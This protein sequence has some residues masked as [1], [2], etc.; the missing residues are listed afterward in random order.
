MYDWNAAARFLQ[1]ANLLDDLEKAAM[2]A[3]D[4]AEQKKATPKLIE[5]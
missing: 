3:N 5:K 2:L 1:K 4:R